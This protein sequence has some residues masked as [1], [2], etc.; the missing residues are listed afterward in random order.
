[1]RWSGD[2]KWW[3]RNDV[4]HVQPIERDRERFRDSVKAMG[5]PLEFNRCGQHDAATPPTWFGLSGGLSKRS[6]NCCKTLI[7]QSAEIKRLFNL[8]NGV[9][10]ETV[11]ES[12]TPGHGVAV[13]GKNN[14]NRNLSAS[15]EAKYARSMLSG[16]WSPDPSRGLRFT[17]T[18]HWP[19]DSIGSM[20]LSAQ[21]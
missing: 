1:M 12:I 5:Y 13:A 7:L 9:K 14:H 16:D 6:G 20:Q 18:V 10:N 3:P 17:M 8:L 11:T 21:A 15:L 19:T 4:S 2:F